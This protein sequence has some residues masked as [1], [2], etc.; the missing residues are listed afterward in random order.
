MGNHL[1]LMDKGM[2][3]KM[4]NEPCARC[5]FVDKGLAGIKKDLLSELEKLRAGETHIHEVHIRHYAAC[6]C[7]NHPS[8]VSFEYRPIRKGTR[9]TIDDKGWSPMCIDDLKYLRRDRCC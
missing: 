6:T 4:N 7:S 2:V 3:G 1:N 5:R 9:S 8:G